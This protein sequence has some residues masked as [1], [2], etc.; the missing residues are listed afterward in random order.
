MR[1]SGRES[2]C[3]SGTRAGKGQE[4][5]TPGRNPRPRCTRK[6]EALKEPH[7]VVPWADLRA[8]I[9]PHPF[10]VEGMRQ[11]DPACRTR[12]W[13]TRCTACGWTTRLPVPDGTTERCDGPRERAVRGF[14]AGRKSSGR[15][16]PSWRR[17]ARHPAPRGTKGVMLLRGLREGRP[18]LDRARAQQVETPLHRD[19]S[20][21]RFTRYPAKQARSGRMRRLP[22]LPATPAEPVHRPSDRPASPRRRSGRAPS[23]RPA[24][25]YPAR[26]PA[27]APPAA[28]R[29][30]AP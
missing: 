23:R 15:P 5:A 19:A 22:R 10:T 29:R 11:R 2:Q 8:P 6:R 13:K 3:A 7:R 25:R 30:P 28:P 1:L 16:Y 26:W 14:A 27:S 4:R 12:Q 9:A 21:P 18:C 24:A 20:T 17:S